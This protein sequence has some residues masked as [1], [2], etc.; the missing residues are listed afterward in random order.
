MSV[1]MNLVIGDE[2]I[3]VPPLLGE[4]FFA[5]TGKNDR[6]K[7]QLGESKNENTRL[8]AQLEESKGGNTRLKAQLKE[9]QDE[10]ARLKAQHKESR[11]R[12][13]TNQSSV[14][15]LRCEKTR[16]DVR[17]GRAEAEAAHAKGRAERAEAEAAHAKAQAEHTSLEAQ[18]A[19]VEADAAKLELRREVDVCKSVLTAR[20]A[21]LGESKDKNTRLEAQVE[22]LRASRLVLHSREL[23]DIWEEFQR[24]AFE[25][26]SL[27]PAGD[28]AWWELSNR[29]P[30]RLF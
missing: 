6:L 22:E 18:L 1:R 7:A 5:L 30:P 21:Q 17:A 12:F 9:S 8:K 10:S 16:A 27:E 23:R 26:G 15:V 28:D 3:G 13:A 4:V 11:T 25:K 2:E 19:K 24:V 29:R 20:N 14:T